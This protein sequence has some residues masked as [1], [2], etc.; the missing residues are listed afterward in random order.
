MATAAVL[1][2]EAVARSRPVF[3][4]GLGKFFSDLRERRGWSLRGAA[5]IAERRKLGLTYQLMFRL[6]QG[7]TK[8]PDPDVLRDLAQLYTLN[9]DDLVD[10]VVTLRY[11]VSLRD[12]DAQSAQ[13][14]QALAATK[15]RATD[16]LDGVSVVLE[17]L[18]SIQTAARS[19]EELLQRAA[20]SE[21]PARTQ[22][23]PLATTRQKRRAR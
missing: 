18:E 5:S 16:L 22:P 4:P 9:Y 1:A 13:T 2:S 20:G 6:E 21:L 11:G 3:H 10:Q 19:A 17:H 7:Q 15:Q 14:R 12:E 23:A 8:N